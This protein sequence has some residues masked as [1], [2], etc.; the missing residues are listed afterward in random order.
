MKWYT[1]IRELIN[2]KDLHNTIPEFTNE[3]IKEILEMFDKKCYVRHFAEAFAKFYN[4]RE[5]YDRTKLVYN[6]ISYSLLPSER[7]EVSNLIRMVAKEKK[8]MSQELFSSIYQQIEQLKI[9]KP[10]FVPQKES[11]EAEFKMVDKF[12]KLEK[13]RRLNLAQNLFLIARDIKKIALSCQDNIGKNY[14]FVEKY[15][16]DLKVAQDEAEKKAVNEWVRL[17]NEERKL[18][19][20]LNEYRRQKKMEATKNYEERVKKLSDF[21]KKTRSLAKVLK[22]ED[23]VFSMEKLFSEDNIRGLKKIINGLSFLINNG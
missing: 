9:D 19:K 14:E 8:E 17:P 1:V 2:D 20:N 6:I 11:D 3:Y 4:L 22:E 10:V 5:P 18:F 7:V 23:I 15:Y 13:K 16:K 21:T 12:Y